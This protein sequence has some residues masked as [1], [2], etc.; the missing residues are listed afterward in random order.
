MPVCIKGQRIIYL[1]HPRKTAG[2]S[3]M[4]TLR[5]AGWR[6]SWA[7]SGPIK[8]HAIATDY[9]KTIDAELPW[10][11]QHYYVLIR[12]PETRLSSLWRY[13]HHYRHIGQDT[14]QS[15]LEWQTQQPHAP[16]YDNG[17]GAYLSR[18]VDYIPTGQPWT[19]LRY[20]NGVD[21]LP[22]LIEPC[23]THNG[24]HKEPSP[25]TPPRQMRLA[26]DTRAWLRDWFAA[27]FDTF[28]YT[29]REWA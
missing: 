18:L 29:P 2:N 21:T 15:W 9:Q 27:D 11:P 17:G 14:M 8:S 10:K 24:A 20:E 22:A 3:V 25:P 23:L 12:H 28:G 4:S 6:I 16:T 26:N 19:E 13:F 7:Q 5:D 1:A